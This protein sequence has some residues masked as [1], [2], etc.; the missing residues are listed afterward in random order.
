LAGKFI[1]E[2]LIYRIGVGEFQFAIQANALGPTPMSQYAR[3][4]SIER[5]QKT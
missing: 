2:N 4:W 1:L 5:L 3:P